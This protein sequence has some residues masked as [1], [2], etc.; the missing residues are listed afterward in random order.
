MLLLLG[1][2]TVSCLN[3]LEAPAHAMTKEV[4]CVLTRGRGKTQI[5]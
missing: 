5:Y 2:E 3:F 1:F 4:V